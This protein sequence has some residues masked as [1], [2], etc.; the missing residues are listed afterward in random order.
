MTVFW[1]AARIWR[2]KIASNCRLASAIFCRSL[3]AGLL[4]RRSG[5]ISAATTCF[6]RPVTSISTENEFG[7][8][9]PGLFHGL[10]NSHHIARSDPEVVQGGGDFLDRGQL[11]KRH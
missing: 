6:G 1:E 10:E 4:A 2:N 7:L 11:R 9:S 8:E 3:K 5:A